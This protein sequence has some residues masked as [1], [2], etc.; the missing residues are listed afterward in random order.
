MSLISS[1][2]RGG[3]LTLA[4]T[5]SSWWSRSQNHFVGA[6]RPRVSGGVTHPPA[7]AVCSYRSNSGWKQKQ[8]Q[9]QQQ[10]Q[11]QQQTKHF[12]G[13]KNSKGGLAFILGTGSGALGACAGVGG[14]VFLVPGLV[15]Y[16]G[17]A[18]PV[19]AGTA[20]ALVVAVSATSAGIYT[21]DAS[22][23][24][25]TVALLSIPAALTTPFGASLASKINPKILRRALGCFLVALSPI[26]P[27]RHHLLNNRPDSKI[28]LDTQSV[29]MECDPNVILKTTPDLASADET[30]N[31]SSVISS[32]ALD[33][34]AVWVRV[35]TAAVGAG[36]GFGAGMLGIGGGSLMTP[37]IAFMHPTLSMTSILGTSFAA[38]FPPALVA[39]VVYN[40]LGLMRARLVL[41]IVLGAAVGASAGAQVVCAVPDDVLRWIFAGVFLA[42]GTR[43][44]RAPLRPKIKCGA[45]QSS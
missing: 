21:T 29:G 37:F 40:K 39:A 22:V 1:L 8:K 27:L 10:Q 13:N 32:N 14:A 24:W 28:E 41:P 2:I 38:M 44:L 19:A 25:E 3:S 34:R 30:V 5:R 23:S 36:V 16:Y 15:R 6:K 9:Q 42:L 18:Q 12:L 4:S 45:S 35:S 43:V 33:F 31:L 7:C 11:Q 26:M 17:L 20:M